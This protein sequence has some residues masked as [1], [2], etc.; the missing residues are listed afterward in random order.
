MSGVFTGDRAK[1]DPP[2]TASTPYGLASCSWFGIFAV[3]SKSN[4]PSP[5]TLRQVPFALTESRAPASLLAA[6]T[7]AAH[8]EAPAA[9][10]KFANACGKTPSIAS[11]LPPWAEMPSTPRASPGPGPRNSATENSWLTSGV[12]V[13]DAVFTHEICELRPKQVSGF[14]ADAGIQ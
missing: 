1:K 12:C 4:A 13:P 11:S 5:A 8:A 9:Q 2:L 7:S 10:E 14:V 6:S 3:K